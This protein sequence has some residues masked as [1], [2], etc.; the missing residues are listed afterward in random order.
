MA[1]SAPAGGT[2]AAAPTNH[3]APTTMA[4]SSS[5]GAA[6]RYVPLSARGRA[7]GSSLAERLRREKEGTLQTAMP[8]DTKVQMPHG[9]SS[10]QTEATTKTLFCQE[11]M[12]RMI[13][14]C[15]YKYFQEQCQILLVQT[16]SASCLDARLVL[17]LL[18]HKKKKATQS[19]IR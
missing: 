8:A 4:A 18:W 12:Q 15:K 3:A 14:V 16:V 7:G 13:V 11:R 9:S 10:K 6:G 5:S 2:K 19:I 17:L 1:I